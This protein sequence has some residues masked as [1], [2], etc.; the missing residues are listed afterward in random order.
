MDLFAYSQIDRIGKLAKA[1]GIEIPRLRGYRLMS[2]ESI[3][4]EEEIQDAI[5]AHNGHIYESACTSCPRFHPLCGWSEFS[6]ATDRL[7]NKYLI[8]ETVTGT[9]TNGS[10][11][12]YLETIGFRWELLHGK[13][14]KRLKYVL[15]RERKDVVNQY[16]TFNK[17]V[18]RDD[19]L[20]VHARI[21]GWNWTQYGGREIEKQ[22]WFL[23]KVDDYF[24]STYCDIFVKVSGAK[25]DG[26]EA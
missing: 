21:G 7:K 26:G 16:R 13:A 23:E 24:D 17:Y 19:V 1:N 12:T 4:T 25:M 15:K 10:G 2:E 3:V 5:K 8:R 20:C 6:P 9:R 14:R 11:Y 22:P 18:G